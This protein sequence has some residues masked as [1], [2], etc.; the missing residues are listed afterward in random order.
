MRDALQQ[1]ESTEKINF[2]VDEYDGE[3]LDESEANRLNIVFHESLKQSFILLIV[4]PIEKERIIFNTNQNKNRFDLL[5]NMELH[6][7]N[8]VMR[9]S[10]EIHK[11]IKVT[12]DLLQKQNTV[13]RH[14]KT[15]KTENEVKMDVPMSRNNAVNELSK[16]GSDSN[17]EPPS[18]KKESHEENNEESSGIP[19]VG[20]DEAQAITESV[21][22]KDDGV[23]MKVL[24]AAAEFLGFTGSNTT[25]TFHYA[26]ADKTGHNISS[27]K[28]A[29]YEVEGKSGFQKVISLIA[30][31]EELKIRK[32]EHVVLHFDTA[33]N[34][35]PEIF[36]FAFSRHFET[37]DK[38]TN[39][40]EEF[41]SREKPILVCSYPTFRGLEHQNITVVIDRDI[42][43][44][45]HYLVETLAICTTYLCVVVLKNSSKLK[46]ITA[47]WKSQQ[48][49]E[50]WSVK[51][52]EN[53]AE[54][55]NFI[56]KLKNIKTRN[57]INTKFSFEYYK[58][59]EKQFEE[60]VTKDGILQ[61][62]DEFEVRKTL[63]ER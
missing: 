63:Q 7:L 17:S 20:L 11:L 41:K 30:I 47:E 32:G 26:V 57:V 22:K 6:K 28:P 18:R 45:Q 49:I 44:V 1:D 38:I 35:I 55:E 5:K 48:V 13:F 21:L 24:N 43:Y 23:V 31:L 34:A 16:P 14:R 40:Y 27:K 4:Q 12:M 61:Y 54:G 15:N 46:K 9:N 2:V 8:L 39:F 50:H 10:V 29:L 19:K 42:N 37:Q 52:S 58:K 56:T 53:A 62:K 60:L 51:I 25:T 33:T 3:D 59:L 36:L